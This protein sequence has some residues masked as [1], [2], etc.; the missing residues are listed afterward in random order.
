MI[1]TG[2]PRRGDLVL[3]ECATLP[4]LGFSTE[5]GIGLTDLPDLPGTVRWS[6]EPNRVDGLYRREA[7]SP[8]SLCL[9]RL[10]WRVV[11]R[12]NRQVFIQM[13]LLTRALQQNV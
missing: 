13:T 1:Y 7:C 5:Y 4:I 12:V 6:A 3:Y 9:L 10:I 8:C 11:I 2:L